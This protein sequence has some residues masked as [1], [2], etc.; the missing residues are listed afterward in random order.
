MAIGWEIVDDFEGDV[1]TKD[2]NR[3]KWHDGAKDASDGG[4][5]GSVLT[6]RAIKLVFV[7]AVSGNLGPVDTVSM[8]INPAEV[9][10]GFKDENSPFV[11][12]KAVNL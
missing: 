12:G 1:A 2:D 10:F 11:D 4:N 9:T 3:I 5:M 6:N 8:T 7:F